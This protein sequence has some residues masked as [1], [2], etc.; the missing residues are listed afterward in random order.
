MNDIHVL[1]RREERA[2]FE[3]TDEVILDLIL[4]LYVV[5][6]SGTYW[7]LTFDEHLINNTNMILTAV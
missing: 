6:N 7:G 2:A 4:Q 1:L 5:C 3:L